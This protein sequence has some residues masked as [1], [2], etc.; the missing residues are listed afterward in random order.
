MDR[1]AARKRAAARLQGADVALMFSYAV[2]CSEKEMATYRRVKDAAESHH[3]GGEFWK[4]T[5]IDRALNHRALAYAIMAPFRF[6]FSYEA[7]RMRFE[8]A[9]S[10]AM[11]CGEY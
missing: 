9:E 2:E 5:M 10:R 3:A 11:L 6:I 4:A 7:E 1:T 8:R